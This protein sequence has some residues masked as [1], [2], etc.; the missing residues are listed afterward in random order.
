LNSL[1]GV[2]GALFI[3][4]YFWLPAIRD[5][6]LMVYETVFNFIDHF[7]T[8]KQLIT[9]Y[10]GYGASVPGP[11]DGMSFYIGSASLFAVSMGII[12][13]VIFWKKMKTL[14]KS[15]LVWGFL[16]FVVSV[17]MM[18]FRSTFLWNLPLL[19]YFQFP[20]RFLT[21]VVLASVF[22]LIPL[23]H[24]KS[25]L[26]YLI[27]GVL[28]VLSIGVGAKNFR[29]QDFLERRDDYYINKYIPVPNA[30]LAYMET[31][32]EYLR[33][34]INS[35]QRPDKTYPIVFS[36]EKF[37]FTVLETDG[38]NSRIV[39]DAGGDT[40][41]Y[42]NKY[43]F[44]GWT[45]K[46]NGQKANIS[47]G[48]PFGQIAVEVPKGEHTLEFDFKETRVN[49]FLDFISLTALTGSVFFLIKKNE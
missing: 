38:L 24:L 7:P 5:S 20:W 27:I 17:F 34:P 18:N 10:F 42:Y 36:D 45:V 32:E 47:A 31:Q 12:L 30:S 2:V 40:A 37:N 9:P 8:I 25:K 16:V 13:T 23:A 46:I 41:I 1:L 33:L 26:K 28:F 6:R 43:F 39:I 22:F 44:P 48:E 19:P 35:K 29:P 15:L 11:F 49:L 14:E 21:M 3:S 4:I